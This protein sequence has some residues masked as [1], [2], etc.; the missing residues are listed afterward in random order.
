MDERAEGRT[1]VG[2][3]ESKNQLYSPVL[4][5]DSQRGAEDSLPVGEALQ[6][7]GPARQS[8]RLCSEAHLD[9]RSGLPDA[10]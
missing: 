5:Q 7:G 10:G 6:L 4:L 1:L 2:G 3:R 8:V 9:D